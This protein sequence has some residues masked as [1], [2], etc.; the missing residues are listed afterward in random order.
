MANYQDGGLAA[1]T[2]VDPDELED[3]SMVEAPGALQEATSGERE[4][5]RLPTQSSRAGKTMTNVTALKRLEEARLRLVDR[6]DKI[7]ADKSGQWLAL[8]QGMLA[9]TQTGGFGESVGAAAGLIGGARSEHREALTN[10]EKDLLDAEVKQQT[11][12]QSARARL[13]SSSTVYHPDDVA[14]FPD[15]SSQWRQIEKQ[16]I[17]HSDG[18]TEHIFTGTENG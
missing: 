1:V 17:V 9:P 6:R 7:E 11:L 16:T 13:G 3:P 12:L 8:A 14:E 4:P 5:A 10:I 2:G 15:D 18:T